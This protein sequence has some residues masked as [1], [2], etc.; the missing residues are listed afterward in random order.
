MDLF[1]FSSRDK[2]RRE[3]DL[4]QELFAVGLE[5]YHLRKPDCTRDQIEHILEEIEP[6]YRSRIVL[7][8]HPEL[9]LRYDLRGIHLSSAS[10]RRGLFNYAKQH[11]LAWRYREQERS[12]TCYSLDRLKRTYPGFTS[13]VLSP[14]FN[15]ISDHKIGSGFEEAKVRE[16]LRNV[17]LPILALGGID[18]STVCKAYN[19]G[20]SGAIVQGAL[21]RSDNP[22]ARFVEIRE[23][24]NQF[25][26]DAPVLKVIKKSSS[27]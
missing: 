18:E 13:L 17:R 2:H 21:W 14:V 9:A 20:F 19:L 1:V 10:Y 3:A 5:C 15:T 27:A 7:H 23:A 6:G 24:L 11:F 4:M 22:A 25:L 12:I 26:L 8:S 16:A